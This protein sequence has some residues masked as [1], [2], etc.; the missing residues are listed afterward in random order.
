MKSESLT[1]SD[2]DQVLSDFRRLCMLR[3]QGIV[4]RS[5]KS[6]F[7]CAAFNL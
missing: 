1:T 2:W 7:L 3:H 6:K 5:V 4:L